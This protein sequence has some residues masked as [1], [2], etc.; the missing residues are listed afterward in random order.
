VFGIFG[1]EAE[2]RDAF[3][4]AGFEPPT[5]TCLTRLRGAARDST[6]KKE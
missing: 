4:G 6:K 2:G 1:S 3:A 5:W